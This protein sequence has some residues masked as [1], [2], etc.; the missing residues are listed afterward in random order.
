M[1]TMGFLTN[2]QGRR[3]FLWVWLIFGLAPTALPNLARAQTI[4]WIRQFGS[5]QDDYARGLAVDSTGV[6][7][8][9]F[10]TGTLPRQTN[11]A[12]LGDAFVRRYDTNGNEL[13]TRQFGTDGDDVA[14]GVA[15]DITG[16]Y[17]V[18][19][20]SGTLPGQTRTEGGGDDVF[21]RKYDR[22]GAEEWT[23]Q[24]GTASRFARQGIDEAYGVAVD[25]SGVFVVGYT[26]DTLPGQTTG[27]GGD[28]FLRKYDGNGTEQWTRQFFCLR[29]PL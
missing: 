12:G 4:Q 25:A 23:R 5:T 17:V 20:S 3:I 16:A 2:Q 7:V 24:F 19:F 22:N 21:V 28:A 18:G 27:G 11:N 15:V 29:K 9:G 10:T 13:W 14:Y 8:V 26:S 1:H 6:Y